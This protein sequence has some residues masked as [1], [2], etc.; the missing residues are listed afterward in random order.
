M[1]SVGAGDIAQDIAD[2]ADRME[3]GRSGILDLP[4]F[5]LE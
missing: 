2:G 1:R 5:L 4:V 3:I